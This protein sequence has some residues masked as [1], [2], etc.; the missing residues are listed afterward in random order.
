MAFL[1]NGRAREWGER[2]IN[3]RV[4]MVVVVVVVVVVV[5]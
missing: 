1:L 4:V 5:G 2:R 3:R